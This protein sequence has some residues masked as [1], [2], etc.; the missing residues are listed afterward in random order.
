MLI[1]TPHFSIKFVSNQQRLQYHWKGELH[2]VSIQ[3][4][5][6]GC[7]ETISRMTLTSA[8]MNQLDDAIVEITILELFYEGGFL[9]VCLYIIIHIPLLIYIQ[10]T[11]L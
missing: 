1:D 6:K 4:K 10:K 8:L 7:W 9:L 5:Q 3:L 2:I 11:V